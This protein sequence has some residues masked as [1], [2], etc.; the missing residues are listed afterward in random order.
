MNAHASQGAIHREML[1]GQQAFPPRRKPADHDMGQRPLVVLTEGTVL[2]A[3]LI[4]THTQ[5]PANGEVDVQPLRKQLAAP[6]RIPRDQYST[7]QQPLRWDR[8]GAAV[9]KISVKVGD[10]PCSI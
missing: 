7:L 10:S 2:K 4:Q 5:K 3:R 8:G 6:L 1:I 9:P